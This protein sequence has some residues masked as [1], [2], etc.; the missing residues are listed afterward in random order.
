MFTIQYTKDDGS[1]TDTMANVT[2][3]T[4]ETKNTVVLA[5]RGKKKSTLSHVL[6]WMSA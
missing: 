4:N 2:A 3:A 6:T 1:S 5:G